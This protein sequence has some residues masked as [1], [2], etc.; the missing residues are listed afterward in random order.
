MNQATTILT[1]A[2]LDAV[3]AGVPVNLFVL[4]A[5][6]QSLNEHVVDPA[7]RALK[8]GEWL[9]LGLFM[10][11]IPPGTSVPGLKSTDTRAQKNRSHLW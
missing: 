11:F 8:A 3:R 10:D 7:P 1:R 2:G 9:R 4:D 6:P 5:A